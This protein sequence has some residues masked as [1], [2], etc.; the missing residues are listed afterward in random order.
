MGTVEG[1]AEP[2]SGTPSES[3]AKDTSHPDVAVEAVSSEPAQVPTPEPVVTTPATAGSHRTRAG[4]V[5]V[6][7]TAFM[8]VLAVLLI[9][10]L[11]N[12][13]S[14]HVRFLGAHGTM[15]LA[16]AMLFSAVAGALL[17]ALASGV[18]VLQ[19]RRTARR[20]SRRG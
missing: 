4:T 9:F 19:L 16:V 15:S 20:S 3:T 18:R 6:A 17:V 7:I 13:G 12:S 2:S 10:V 1:S 11:Q 5:W 14:V 8:V